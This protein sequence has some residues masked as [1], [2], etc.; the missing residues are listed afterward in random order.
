MDRKLE[1]AFRKLE[2]AQLRMLGVV[3][4]CSEEQRTRKPSASEWSMVQVMTHLMT[5]ESAI[6]S[7]MRN[8][9]TK[10]LPLEKAGL[11]S[12]LGALAMSLVL[13][14]RKKIKRPPGVADPTDT[15]THKQVK[16]GWQE[17]RAQL[18]Q[19]LDGFPNEWMDKEIFRHPVIGMMNIHQTVA[20]MGEHVQHHQAQVQRLEATG[21]AVG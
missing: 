1:N 13:R 4:R 15:L 2:E 9:S 5:T 3:E 6:L 21:K 17:G 12:S 11:R 14:Y 16:Q 8:K 20:F 18:R 10:G 19:F 7:Y